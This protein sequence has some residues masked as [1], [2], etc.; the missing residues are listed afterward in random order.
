MLGVSR[1]AVN[2]AARTLQEAGLIPYRRDW[3]SVVDRAGL[4]ESSCECNE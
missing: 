3:V 2:K 1:A 4:Q